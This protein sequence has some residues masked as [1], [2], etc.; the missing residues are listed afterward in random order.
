[1]QQPHSS[2]LRIVRLPAADSGYNLCASAREVV[3]A[4]AH[5]LLSGHVGL[6][7][8]QGVYCVAKLGEGDSR[9][10]VTAVYELQ[11]CTGAGSAQP[12]HKEWCD[13]QLLPD[14]GLLLSQKSSARILFAQLPLCEGE[15]G[16]VFLFG[17][18]EGAVLSLATNRELLLSGGADGCVRLWGLD[19]GSLLD[20]CRRQ[21]AVGGHVTAVAF[22]GPLL[23]AAGTDQ[24]IVCMYDISTSRLVVVQR[25]TAGEGPIT[26]LS[27][28]LTPRQVYDVATAAA[29][30]GPDGGGVLVAPVGLPW[31]SSPGFGAGF[32]DG[33]GTDIH[34]RSDT[35]LAVASPA[36]WMKVF[37]A[38]RSGEDAWQ[39]VHHCTLDGPPYLSYSP[40]GNYLA[41]GAGE[42]LEVLN[43]TTFELVHRHLFQRGPLAGAG[44][45]PASAGG[46]S[47]LAMQLGGSL[48]GGT[49][50]RLFAAPAGMDPELVQLTLPLLDLGIEGHERRP[51]TNKDERFPDS[52]PRAAINNPATSSRRATAASALATTSELLGGL[53][54]GSTCPTAAVTNEPVDVR[55]SGATDGSGQQPAALSSPYPSSPSARRSLPWGLGGV[56]TG[57]GTELSGV[58]PA[59]GWQA[60]A[61]SPSASS[62][63]LGTGGQGGRAAAATSPGGGGAKGAERSPSPAE[64]WASP[65]WG[66][67]GAAAAVAVA[68]ASSPRHPLG[69]WSRSPPKSP[70]VTT[71][72]TRT[73]THGSVD[74][75][76]GTE[77]NGAA[78]AAAAHAWQAYRP[79]TQPAPRSWITGL[80]PRA[81]FLP[82]PVSSPLS[83]SSPPRRQPAAP[84]RALQGSPVKAAAPGAGAGVMEVASPTTDCFGA[85]GAVPHPVSSGRPNWEGF[86][87]DRTRGREEGPDVEVE[88]GGLSGVLWHEPECELPCSATL[89]PATSGGAAVTA[90]PSSGPSHRGEGDSGAGPQGF[91]TGA[92]EVLEATFRFQQ[93]QHQHDH[94]QQQQISTYQHQQ[95]RE[96]ERQEQRVHDAS[97]TIV[98]EA[99]E[100]GSSS[101]SPRDSTHMANGPTA[102][103]AADWAAA[104]S[105]DPDPLSR[106]AFFGDA[107]IAALNDLPHETRQD[108]TAAA[109]ATDGTA[110]YRHGRQLSPPGAGVRPGL[111]RGRSDRGAQSADR[112]Q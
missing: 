89:L 88:A 71:A 98:T 5:P 66:G 46:S 103:A 12:L 94:H 81:D 78:S 67:D 74:M 22:A 56:D 107:L 50:L 99:A 55:R 38:A 100:E 44:F 64:P 32:D 77:A 29:P 23:V 87:A 90:P 4:R 105:G 25:F 47:L 86:G 11:L 42:R 104:G 24:G 72:N 83:S 92:A 79:T 80:P 34:T 108:L 58:N 57:I 93:L 10:S 61:P 65:S 41:V 84:S 39:V 110:P 13:F 36:G 91:S 30:R 21:G 7:D 96:W 102:T 19:S 109:A 95:Q 16:P 17:C 18:H 1:M 101:P 68:T 59:W 14:G 33:S 37:R 76:E 43:A 69:S 51:E 8:C 106:T 70:A 112:R 9:A 97:E 63:S 31:R 73:G 28:R 40:D 85:A 49:R 52:L 35:L 75:P 54:L 27:T 20:C 6:V 45:L 53:S 62:E 111:G 48:A 3:L 2:T 82:Q 26:A 60:F 15:S